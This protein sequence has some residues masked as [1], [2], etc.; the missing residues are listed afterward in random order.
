VEPNDVSDSDESGAVRSRLLNLSQSLLECEDPAAVAHLVTAAAGDVL[1]FSGAGVRLC[2]GDRLPVAAIGGTAS[3]GDPVDR[4]TVPVDGSPQ[5]RAF[6]EGDV[7]LDRIEP[8]DPYDR[9]VF[10]ESMYVCIGEYGV[11]CAGSEDGTF[12][13]RDVELA[14]LLASMAE[15]A[16]R[17]VDR[18]ETLEHH[19]RVLETVEGMV[20]AQDAEG[21]FTVVTEPL[22]AFL[23]YERERLL[24]AHVSVPL[25]AD[26][27]ERGREMVRRLVADPDRDSLTFEMEYRKRDGSVAPIEVELS[28]LTDEDGDCEGC[29]GVVQDIADRRER[30]RYLQVLNRVLRHNLRNDLTVVLGLAEDVTESADDESVAATARK[31]RTVAAGLV[32]LSEEARQIEALLG[33]DPVDD[34]T[35]AL[36]RIVTDL[37]EDAGETYP[38]A[39]LSLSTTAEPT[40]RGDDRLTVALAQLVENAIQHNDGD[41]HVD[42]RVGVDD[43]HATVAVADDGPGIPPDEY[44]VVTGDREASQLTHT[45]GLGLWLVRWAVDGCHGTVAFAER[46]G[47]GS[48]VTVELPLADAT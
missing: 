17:R 46:E 15:T 10:T 12:S 48:V 14:E 36:D 4:P 27:V 7:V 11:L 8:D 6:R 42:V 9:E 40:V 18:R 44:A 25:S 37:I 20:W 19:S 38:G 16:F 34:E 43:D 33:R 23:G 1:E 31:L 22:A 21:N 30:E 45:S 5:G 13:E 35:L 2:E 41:P 3:E 24:G 28:L 47:G 39:S 26:N 32:D 29:V